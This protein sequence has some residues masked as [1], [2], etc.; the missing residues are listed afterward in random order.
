MRLDPHELDLE[1]M[2]Q[3][4]EDHLTEDEALLLGL[5]ADSDSEDSGGLTRTSR[6]YR[7]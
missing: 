6:R 4:A 7:A 5:E 1:Y 2:E 3:E